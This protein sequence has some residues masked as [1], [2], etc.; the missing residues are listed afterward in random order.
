[1]LAPKGLHSGFSFTGEAAGSCQEV[2]CSKSDWTKSP[3]CCKIWSLQD[4]VSH[5]EERAYWS[6]SQATK[7]SS[8]DFYFQKL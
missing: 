4:L 3:G 5:Y 6:K 8:L 1:M 2:S 7:Y